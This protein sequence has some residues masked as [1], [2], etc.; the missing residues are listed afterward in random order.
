MLSED[1]GRIVK[2][3]VNKKDIEVFFDAFPNLIITHDTYTN[4]Y[5]F[6]DKIITFEEYNRI[7]KENEKNVALNK[8][9]SMLSKR[10]FTRKELEDKLKVK[11]F[12]KDTIDYIIAYSLEH[13][14]INDEI[15]AKEYKEVLDNKNYGKLKI[16][17]LLKNKGISSIVIDELD[18]S[19]EKEYIKALNY[20]ELLNNKHYEK[21]NIK[22][23]QLIYNNLCSEGF[24][25]KV[26]ECVIQQMKTNSA[27]EEKY[28]LQRELIILKSKNMNEEKIIH[29]LMLKGYQY[30]LIKKVMEDL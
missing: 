25:K 28:N 26:I 1:I 7:F 4:Y 9:L 14:L 8:A 24:E 2:I 27:E 23:K 20:L 16:I 11:K 13:N 3:K 21:S 15:Y 19:E 12:N 17:D 29:K 5:L 6:V 22:K 10:L 30:S 18:F